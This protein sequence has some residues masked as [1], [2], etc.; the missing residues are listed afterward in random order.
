M[1]RGLLVSPPFSSS[2][3]FL[4]KLSYA[5]LLY[6]VDIESLLIGG[7][8]FKPSDVVDV[9]VWRVWGVCGGVEGG[10]YNKYLIYYMFQDILVHFF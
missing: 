4:F 8:N 1:E 2:S 5:T 10:C 6:K 3:N 9:F 7:V